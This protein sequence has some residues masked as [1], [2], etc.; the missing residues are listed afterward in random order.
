MVARRRSLG[1]HVYALTVSAVG[2]GLLWLL[3]SGGRLAE[4]RQ[5]PPVFWALVVCLV[6]NET[7][8]VLLPRAGSQGATTA[9]TFAFAILLGWGTR[10]ATFALVLGVLVADV[11]RRAA[12]EKVLFN[13]GQYVLVMVV[14]GGL[15]EALGGERPFTATQLLAFAAAALVFFLGNLVLVTVVTTLA[16]GRNLVSDLKDCLRVEALPFGMVF[17]MA[18]VVL[19]VAEAEVSLLPLLLLPT[20]AVWVALKTTV[21][22]DEQRATAELAASQAKAVAEEQARLTAIEHALVEKLQE[23]DRL[24]DDLLAAVSHELRTPLA[25]MLGALATLSAREGQLT[26]PQRQELIG[27]AVRQGDRLK[28]QIEQLLLAARLEG[29][30]QEPPERP[31]VDA[32]ALARDAVAA[33]RAA[34]PARQIVLDAGQV[35]PVRAVP[36]AVL[37]V[38]GNLLDNAA[39]HAPDRAPIRVEARRVGGLAV[40]AVEDSGPGVPPAERERIFERF[41]QLDS[42]ATRLAS[43]VGLGLYIARQLANAQDGELLLVD[44]AQAGPGARFEL[45]L[46]MAELSYRRPG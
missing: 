39:K 42:G 40:V 34:Y 21:Q 29:S 9:E 12:P 35:L 24:K 37:Q 20:L 41:T 32:A 46:P 19:V 11:L 33:A 18:P 17:G 8:L 1:L 25:G 28:L 4:L 14:A 26:D 27:M 31:V 30:G 3:G 13:I 36:E 15:Y 16:Y 5:Q 23:S 43:G 45:R 10:A 2:L 7:A 38:L 6:V 44:P 22:A